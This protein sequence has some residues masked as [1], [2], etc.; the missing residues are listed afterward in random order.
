M[1]NNIKHVEIEFG[2]G[3]SFFDEGKM[4]KAM[5]SFL[6]VIEIA[7]D[8]PKANLYLGKIH[9]KRKEHD[10]AIRFFR[11]SSLDE[12]ILAEALC[13]EK[14][15]D[16]FTSLSRYNQLVK[17]ETTE[18]DIAAEAHYHI[19]VYYDEGLGPV[20]KDPNKAIECYQQSKTALAYYNMAQLYEEMDDTNKA[21]EAYK[22]AGELGEGDAYYNL[23]IYFDNKKMKKEALE[24]YRK[25]AEECNHV[26]CAYAYAVSLDDEGDGEQARQFYE[27]AAKQ[28]YDDAQ[29][30]LAVIE[31]SSKNYREAKKYYELAAA[32]GHVQALYNIGVAYDEGSCGYPQNYNK[33]FLYY[34]R[35]ANLGSAD[36]YFNMGVLFQEGQGVDVDFKLAVDALKKA[37]D[38]GHPRALLQIG[39]IMY[40]S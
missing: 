18:K 40:G 14:K 22:K 23:G 36:A 35:A 30:N 11:A 1:E 17:S 3:K 13:L 28:G 27:I 25:G 20:L 4:H 38:L 33:A 31:E 16:Y 26:D 29:Y 6:K 15:E 24:T 5:D 8:H 21:I 2:Y 7:P 32:Q 9:A 37:H 19:G 10:E 12:A 39:S 34:N